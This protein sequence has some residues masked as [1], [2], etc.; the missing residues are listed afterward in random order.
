MSV[1]I[2]ATH[3]NPPTPPRAHRAQ[4]M[5]A[6][7]YRQRAPF[8]HSVSHSV[9]MK[10]V[11]KHQVHVRQRA[12]DFIFVLFFFLFVTVYLHS[13]IDNML[14]PL[15]TNIVQTSKHIFVIKRD[16]RVANTVSAA[17]KQNAF[18][19]N[20]LR[21]F[22]FSLFSF[23]FFCHATA[24]FPLNL[25]AWNANPFTWALSLPDNTVAHSHSDWWIQT[26]NL[27]AMLR[28][29]HMIII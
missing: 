3:M 11:P 24:V 7:W 5:N 23:F 16:S 28:H 9:V 18:S 6:G 4:L 2:T 25:C 12:W 14:W 21:R 22:F 20:L 13:R 29:V 26:E 1:Q 10:I 17:S 15:S 8:W 27:M 19:R